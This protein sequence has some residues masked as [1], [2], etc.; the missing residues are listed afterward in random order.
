MNLPDAT[1]VINDIRSAK[2]ATAIGITIFEP[3]RKIKIASAEATTAIIEKMRDPVCE[4]IIHSLSKTHSL[5][6][7]KP[8]VVL[9]LP[10]AIK[11]K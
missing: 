8:K 9:S 3:L 10:G 5:F 1:Q 7:T 6:K 2:V 4:E 11:P